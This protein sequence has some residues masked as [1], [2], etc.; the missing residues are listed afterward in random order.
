MCALLQQFVKLGELKRDEASLTQYGSNKQCLV[1]EQRDRLVVL[2]S[3]CDTQLKLFFFS[4]PA[5]DFAV[6]ENGNTP[7]RQESVE[8]YHALKG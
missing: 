3:G 6:A 8:R 1:Q 5:F 2:V 7:L 4:V